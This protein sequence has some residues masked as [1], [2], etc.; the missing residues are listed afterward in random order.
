MSSI[1]IFASLRSVYEVCTLRSTEMTF[2]EVFVPFMSRV[3]T[4]HQIYQISLYGLHVPNGS[5][6]TSDIC[7][8][9]VQLLSNL[10]YILFLPL[11]SFIFSGFF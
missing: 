8:R 9:P 7:T 11:I 4:Y 2:Y 3:P 1:L 5:D 6:L 10:A